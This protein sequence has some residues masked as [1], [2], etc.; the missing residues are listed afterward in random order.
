[1]K[2]EYK[3]EINVRDLIGRVCHMMTYFKRISGSL[4]VSRQKVRMG[5]TSSSSCP[6]TGPAP[7]NRLPNM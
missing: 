7:S 3:H 1:M 4:S 6:R 5:R 2:L